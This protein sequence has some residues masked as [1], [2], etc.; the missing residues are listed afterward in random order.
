MVG[1]VVMF[2]IESKVPNTKIRTYLDALWWCV[3][4]VTIVGYGEIV[5]ISNVGRMVAIFYMFFGI[6]MISTLLSVNT[7]TF[8][9]R[10]Y[11]KGEKE[12]REELNELIKRLSGIEE[13]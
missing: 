11:E 4:A 8:Y 1:T 6:A 7:N 13:K 3:A 2:N 5:P 9:K 10:R 12:K